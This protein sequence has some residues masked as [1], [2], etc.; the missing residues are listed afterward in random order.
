MSPGQTD[1]PPLELF[2]VTIRDGS[3]VIDFQFERDDVRLLYQAIEA[4]GFK[5]IEIGHG[6]GL[7]A[8]AKKEAAAA[9]DAD[10]LRAAAESRRSSKFGAFFIPGIGDREHLRWARNEFGMDFVRIGCEPEKADAAIPFFEYARELGYEVMCNFMKTYTA[11]AAKIGALSRIAWEHGAHAVYVVDS[12]GGMDPPQVGEYVRAIA[13][14]CP[15]RIGFHGHNNL[16]LANS[17]SISAWKNGATLIDCSIGGLGRSAGNTRTELFLPVMRD[18]GQKLP[19]DT[20]A[21][22]RIWQEMIQPLQQ[23]RPASPVDIASAYARIHS[24]LIGPFEAAASRHGISLTRLLYAYGDAVR[25]GVMPAVDD[26]ASQLA[27]AGDTSVQLPLPNRALL[28]IKS[29]IGDP[30]TLRN[31]LGRAEEV[32]RA[33]AVL[34]KKACLPLVMLVRIDG[35]LGDESSMLA[36]YLYHDDHFVV[37]RGWFASIDAFTAFLDRCRGSIEMIAFEQSSPAVRQELSDRADWRGSERILWLDLQR[38]KHHLLL[39]V[40]EQVVPSSQSADVLLFGGDP[41]RLAQFIS[42]GLSL[43]RFWSAAIS[44]RALSDVGLLLLDR[45]G[46]SWALKNADPP[47]RFEVAILLAPASPVELQ[48]VLLRV[49]DRG[50]VIDCLGQLSEHPELLRAIPRHVLTVN[51]RRSVSGALLNLLATGVREHKQSAAHSGGLLGREHG[52]DRHAA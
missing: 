42:P 28:R 10:Y 1:S 35:S 19:Y 27:K 5:Y 23:R 25:T 7:N 4:A 49:A 16:E 17:N 37:L 18:L 43:L 38:H 33:G 46:D 14:N 3:Y 13:D 34:A 47:D 40:L 32:A 30:Y 2:D 8:S 20:E 21:I 22:H 6:L 29:E 48:A 31:T 12:A 11:P 44:R 51:L 26:L 50:T 24:G 15:A 45:Q 41:L 39:S 9:S 52:L 36:E